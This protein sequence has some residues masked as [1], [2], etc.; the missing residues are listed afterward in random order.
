MTANTQE[1][2]PRDRTAG[3]RAPKVFPRNAP[4]LPKRLS[5]SAK[6][7]P[8]NHPDHQTRAEKERSLRRER[9]AVEHPPASRA[10][11]RELLRLELDVTRLVAQDLV[12][13]PPQQHRARRVAQRGVVDLRDDFR[14]D[15]DRDRDLQSAEQVAEQSEHAVRKR[16]PNQRDAVDREKPRQQARMAL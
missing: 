13:E 5:T 10:Q 6:D 9:H 12:A 15:Q 16:R 8:V 1:R 11:L 2:S 14:R 3:K 4:E 7:A